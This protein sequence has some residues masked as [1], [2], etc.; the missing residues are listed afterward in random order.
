VVGLF[1]LAASETG[2]PPFDQTAWR[3]PRG[4]FLPFFLL[5]LGWLWWQFE[6]WR[7]DLFVLTSER[8][9]HRQGRPLRQRTEN[10]EVRLADA[11][12]VCYVIPHPVAWL[13][14]YGHIAIEM[15]DRSFAFRYAADPRGTQQQIL[16]RMQTSHPDGATST[17]PQA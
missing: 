12:G 14:D 8:V 3:L 5:L 16:G 15:A 7:R 4:F 2:L 6:G 9:I 13:L 10:R 11:A 1:L 17:R